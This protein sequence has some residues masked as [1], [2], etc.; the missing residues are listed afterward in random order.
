MEFKTVDELLTHTQ[1]FMGKTFAEI[2]TLGLFETAGKDKGIFGKI[3]ET[4]GYGYE[5]NSNP[6]ADFE[7]LGIELKVTGYVKNSR[8]YKAKER[9]SL[10]MIDYEKI[11]FE[12]YNFSKLLFKN[13]RLLMIWYEYDR[14][15]EKKDFVV[16]HYN[17][18]D[19]SQDDDVFENDFNLIKQKVLDGK[20]HLLSEGDTSY[21]GACTKGGAQSKPRKQPYSDILAKPRAFSLKNAYM[22]GVLRR[23]LDG[24]IPAFE[25]V[26]ELTALDYLNQRYQKY[27]GWTQLEILQDITGETY[28]GRVPKNLGKMISDAV[29]GKDTELKTKHDLFTKTEFI[30]KNTPVNS[31]LYPVERLSF[32]NLRLS[33]FESPWEESD[34]KQYFEQVTI[35]L[36]CYEAQNSSVKNGYR[37]LKGIKQLAFTDADLESFRQTYECV[38]QAILQ[39]DV[40]LLPYPG[41]F[42]GQV[43]EVA[44]KGQ[45]GDDAYNHFFEKDTTKVCFMLTKEFVKMKIDQSK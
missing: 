16:T 17:L 37:T 2:D 7:N 24:T 5:L 25:T 28:E 27:F 19:M 20:A 10:S 43:L 38:H 9:L 4:G 39:K 13:K 8:G 34:W 1:T 11:V 15:K 40:S 3:I 30:I 23:L 18:Y 31:K 42:E 22:T 36:V 21:L 33:E 45:G 26:R 44:P 35:L 6:A 41:S 32:R 29:V 14:S 12:E